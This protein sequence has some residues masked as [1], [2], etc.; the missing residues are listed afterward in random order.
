MKKY[1]QMFSYAGSQKAEI[2][3]KFREH[4]EM[5]GCDTGHGVAIA[6]CVLEALYAGKNGRPHD[7]KQHMAQAIVAHILMM[8]GAI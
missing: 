7:T 8:E 4:K 1:K 2:L 5:C 3:R 6:A